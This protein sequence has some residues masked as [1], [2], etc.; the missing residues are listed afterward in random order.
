MDLVAS[1]PH[2]WQKGIGLE[3]LGATWDDL[4]HSLAT[5]EL[6]VHPYTKKKRGVLQL[7]L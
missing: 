4:N 6:E 3:I 7:A 2:T 1:F 5:I